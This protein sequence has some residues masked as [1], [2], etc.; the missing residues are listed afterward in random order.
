[1]LK[2]KVQLLPIKYKK[3]V[4]EKLHVKGEAAKLVEHSGYFS[5]LGE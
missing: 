2:L 3:K 4:V 1:M 5:G